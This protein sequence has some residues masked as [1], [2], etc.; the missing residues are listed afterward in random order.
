[1]TFLR[2]VLPETLESSPS[3]L[4]AIKATGEPFQRPFK[5]ALET[6][7]SPTGQLSAP[8]AHAPSQQNSTGPEMFQPRRQRAPALPAAAPRK[9]RIVTR[10]ESR[11]DYGAPGAMAD[12]H[13]APGDSPARR[14]AAPGPI[15]ARG[16]PRAHRGAAAADG[17]TIRRATGRGARWRGRAR[18]S[19][20]C[21]AQLEQVRVL[22]APLRGLERA[23][24]GAACCSQR[25]R[26]VWKVRR[27]RAACRTACRGEAEVADAR[28][29][30]GASLYDARA[31]R[32]ST[33]NTRTCAH[34][35]SGRWN[36][37]RA[38][39][40]SC[41]VCKYKYVVGRLLGKESPFRLSVTQRRSAELSW[42]HHTELI[43][44]FGSRTHSDAEHII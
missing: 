21:G 3:E 23:R 36:R 33:F 16:G 30:D 22:P 15:A 29:Q 8:P 28:V 39:H 6:Y 5:R 37:R 43:Y 12:R 19:K 31:R 38:Q 10:F 1:M 17:A 40:R 2:Y 20:R 18:R 24:A 41:K 14:G 26:G 34:A 4:R 7:Q 27:R 42:K 11:L 35:S 44:S 13:G 32:C 9:R 25:R